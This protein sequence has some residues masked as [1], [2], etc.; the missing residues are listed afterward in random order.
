VMQTN[1]A[2]SCLDSMG[3]GDSLIL[4]SN[5]HTSESS[6][7]VPRPSS[8]GSRSSGSHSEGEFDPHSYLLRIYNE[9]KDREAARHKAQQELG[10][11]PSTKDLT[12]AIER[13]TPVASREGSPEVPKHS[14]DNCDRDDMK[15]F[16]S[17]DI[18]VKQVPNKFD[19][20][21]RRD[22]PID[23]LDDNLKRSHLNSSQL[24]Y[25]DTTDYDSSAYFSCTGMSTV[26]S[27]TS[28]TEYSYAPMYRPTTAVI[29]SIREN[30]P[31]SSSP[32]K[33]PCVSSSR[34]PTSFT[35][36]RDAESIYNFRP[37]MVDELPI[38]YHGQPASRVSSQSSRSIHNTSIPSNGKK[39]P[40]EVPYQYKHVYADLQHYKHRLNISSEYCH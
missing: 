7:D 40:L 10:W 1:Q 2:K 35:P 6:S 16:K 5:H 39:S 13:L 34:G 26:E 36:P 31:K 17:L 19:K 18:S 8:T 27:K 12:M 3:Q 32:T 14:H 20:Y 33:S 23:E 30:S 28:G 22:S 11:R 4:E 25:S 9:Q 37:H 21:I 15:S 24:H 38:P 29:R